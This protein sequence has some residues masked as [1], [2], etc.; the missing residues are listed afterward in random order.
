MNNKKKFVFLALLGLGI[1]YIFEHLASVFFHELI[2]SN[3]KLDNNYLILG[4]EFLFK[5]PILI[6]F[7][8]YLLYLY[9]EL[10]GQ[11]KKLNSKNIIKLFTIITSVSLIIELILHYIGIKF[12]GKLAIY[13]TSIVLKL[14]ELNH[15]IELIKKIYD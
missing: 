9:L 11:K 14:F 10:I 2:I 5:L 1:D 4:L 6:T 15:Q 8:I 13:A 12:E 7:I 3:F